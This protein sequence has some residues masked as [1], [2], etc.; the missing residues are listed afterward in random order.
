MRQ[1]ENKLRLH[2]EWGIKVLF[3]KNELYIHSNVLFP[4]D[5]S[6]ACTHA[7]ARTH[8][9]THT[10]VQEKYNSF[11]YESNMVTVS[12]NGQCSCYVTCYN[13]HVT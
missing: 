4:A 13:V 10:I 8:T 3:A 2:Q 6:E 9:H 1:I 7:R 12:Y 11:Q 5:V